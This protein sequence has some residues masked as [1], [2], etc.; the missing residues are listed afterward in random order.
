V[1]SGVRGRQGR[2]DV[3]LLQEIITGAMDGTKP[4][5]ELLRAMQVLAKRGGASDLEE[6]VRKESNGYGDDDVLP[7]YRGPFSVNPL[8]HFSGPSG[9]QVKKFP[10]GERSFPAWF[11]E[12]FSFKLYWGMKELEDIADQGPVMYLPWSADLVACANNLIESGEIKLIPM[13]GLVSVDIPVTRV[14]LVRA[15]DAVRGRVLD[16]ALELEQVSPELG[17]VAGSTATHKEEISAKFNM[18]VVTQS[19]NVGE[20]VYPNYGVSITSGDPG[21][22]SRYLRALGVDDEVAINELTEAAQTSEPEDL[23]KQDSKLMRAVKKVGG[24]VGTA[25]VNAST[26]SGF[27]LVQKAMEGYFGMGGG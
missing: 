10:I 25:S 3:G 7:Q 14:A 8:A 16:L 1:G 9:S 13:H 22:L 18:N 20:T 17:E 24:L 27:Q 23:Q 11:K 4:V 2:N 19:V 12:S 26:S 21:S 15:I 5:S 6:W